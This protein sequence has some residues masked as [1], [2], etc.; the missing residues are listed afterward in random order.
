LGVEGDGHDN[1]AVVEQIIGDT[2]TPEFAAQTADEYAHLLGRLTDASLRSIAVWK[3]E[4]YSNEEI[5]ARLGCVPRTV[6]RKLAV[7]RTLWQSV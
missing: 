2:P 5:A 1:Q 7:I 6:E 3:M 4:G